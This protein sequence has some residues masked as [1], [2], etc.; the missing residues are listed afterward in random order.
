MQTAEREPS[1]RPFRARSARDLG[2]AVKYF[3]G[4]AGLTQVELAS[5][6]GLHRTYL[7][8]LESGATTEALER[9]M[10][11]F[12]ELGVRVELVRES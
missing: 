10:G 6:A 7:T 8:S 9:L 11:L 5:R 3:R 12:S 1:D 2:L 4:L